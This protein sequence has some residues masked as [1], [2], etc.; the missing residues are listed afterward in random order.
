MLISHQDHFS[1]V[2]HLFSADIQCQARVGNIQHKYHEEVFSTQ[3]DFEEMCLITKEKMMTEI[4]DKRRRLQEDTVISQL[5]FGKCG[6]L[7][8]S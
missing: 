1:L 7:A 3:Q 8:F 4:R 6:Y 2:P 5:N